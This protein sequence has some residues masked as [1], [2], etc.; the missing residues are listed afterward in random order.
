MGD[1][2]PSYDRHF[3]L[4]GKVVLH[5][6]T[7]GAHKAGLDAVMLAASVQDGGKSQKRIVDLGAGVGTAGLCV[8]NRLPAASAILVENDPITLELAN[9]TLNDP[10]NH[11]LNG[12]ASTL[13]ADVT[14]RGDARLE[15]GLSLNMADHV[16]MNPPY[17]DA[18]QVRTSDNAA[19]QAAHVLA[20]DGLEPW[21]RTAAAILVSGGM[22]S[23]I[24]PTAS[25]SN[26]LSLME[27]R[28][29]GISVFPLYKG[30]GEDAT[31]VIV[32]G[33]KGSRA[34]M[35]LLSG[36]VLHQAQK[37]DVSRREWTDEANAVLNGEA[38][39]VI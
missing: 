36:L 2:S 15:A 38:G 33:Q 13:K 16:I 7:G 22:L 5:Q 28:F 19:R 3:V 23:V 27:G 4:G 30:A 35:R 29:G 24:F 34:P 1:K 10:D 9:A 26:L 12:R 20:D 21:F 18:A 31:R 25:L 11:W 17:Y 6:Q 8:L 39:L 14:L 32:C 37:G